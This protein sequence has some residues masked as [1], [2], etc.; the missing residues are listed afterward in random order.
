MAYKAL[1][2]FRDDDTG[3][4]YKAGDFFPVSGEVSDTRLS[5][6]LST[7]NKIGKPVI[8][9]VEAEYPKLL[10]GG[11]Y[12]LSNGDKVQGKAAAFEAENALK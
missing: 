10:G 1:Q 9:E 3:H 4:V 5:S 7:D 11:Y 6:L 2:K 12:E 8:K